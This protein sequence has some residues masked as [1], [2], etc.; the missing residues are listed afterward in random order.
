ADNGGQPD[1]QDVTEALAAAGNLEAGLLRRALRDMAPCLR[2]LP[3]R[4]GLLGVD[5]DLVAR[6][7]PGILKLADQLERLHG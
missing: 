2:G 3:Q 5:A 7:R 4:M 6:L 1:W